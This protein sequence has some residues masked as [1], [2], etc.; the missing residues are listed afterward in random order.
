MSHWGVEIISQ[1]LL[2]MAVPTERNMF[3]W[4]ML[5]I[6]GVIA[7]KFSTNIRIVMMLINVGFQLKIH[8]FLHTKGSFSVIDKIE[9]DCD[10]YPDQIQLIMADSGDVRSKKQVNELAN[11]IAH[12]ALSQDVKSHDTIALMMLNNLDYISIWLGIGKI[13]G[14]TALINTNV[15]GKPLAHSIDTALASSQT[16]ILIIDEELMSVRTEEIAVLRS[17]GIKIFFWSTQSSSTNKNLRD[18]VITFPTTQVDRK[19]RQSITEKDPILH[20]YTSGTTGLPKACKISQTRFQAASLFFP[21]FCLLRQ[22]VDRIYTAL[23]LYHSA[24]GAIAVGG[25]L[26]GNVPLVLRSKFSVR[27]FAKDCVDYRVTVLQYIGE[28]CRYLANAP[29]NPL[30]HQV[31]LRFAL[32]NGMRPEYWK[33]FQNRYNVHFIAEFYSATEGNIGLF[34]I[35]SKPG[36]LGFI[37]SLIGDVLSPF[38]LVRFDPEDPSMPLRDQNGRCQIVGYNEPGLLIGQI[39]KGDVTRRYD[40]YS[41]S[42]ATRQKVL[43][44][45]FRPGDQYFN[46]GDLLT[47]DYFGFYFWSDRV[48]DTFR[49]K[50]ENVSTTEVSEII[51]QYCARSVQDNTVYGVAVPQR[52]GRAGMAIILMQTSLYEQTVNSEPNYDC[53]LQEIL[54]ACK[55]HLPIYARPV[56]IRIRCRENKP[57]PVTSTLKYMKGDLV[58]ESYEMSQQKENDKDAVFLL[59]YSDNSWKLVTRKVIEELKEGKFL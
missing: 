42:Q 28:L 45:V 7:W 57:L 4:L 49:W 10:L 48:G 37:P 52:D 36:A 16:K 8:S 17:Q 39:T 47:R 54:A 32:G 31:K 30:D 50:G 56:F 2:S 24:A 6:I 23:P 40:G 59:N 9:N 38:R 1:R 11:Q 27:A 55:K 33:V 19:Y 13:G 12:W 21:N 14:S 26:R 3:L 53:A 51:T 18:I 46:T 25:A 34:N 44:D 41:D 43:T 5:A 15:T 35:L 22:N 20:I 29:E 58:K